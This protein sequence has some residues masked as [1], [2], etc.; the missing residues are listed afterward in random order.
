[1]A[2]L[3]ALLV[4]LLAPR[5]ALAAGEDAAVQQTVKSVLE[6]EYATAAYGPA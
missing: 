4:L 6:E 1:V 5:A 3:L 2:A